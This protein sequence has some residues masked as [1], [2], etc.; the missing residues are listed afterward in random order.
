ME[1]ELLTAFIELAEAQIP[2]IRSGIL[3]CIESSESGEELSG[4]VRLT[5]SIKTSAEEIGLDEMALAMSPLE[6]AL[7]SMSEGRE[8]F[9]DLALRKALDEVAKIEELVSQLRQIAGESEIDVSEFVETSFDN[10]G[11]GNALSEEDSVAE[12]DDSTDDSEFEIDEEMMEIFGAEAEG[13][14]ANIETSLDA[15]TIDPSN[16]DALWEVRRNAHT[17]KGA[18]GIVGLKKPSE[19]AHRV[20]DLLDRLAEKNGSSSSK[21]VTLLKRSLECMRSLTNGDTSPSVTAK[22]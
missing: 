12:Y 14:L 17:F 3:V 18:A 6:A 10:L 1:P 5:R 13:L 22:I 8:A 20:E 11:I 15:L 16:K 7:T 9:S 2:G 4:P 19:L 21:L